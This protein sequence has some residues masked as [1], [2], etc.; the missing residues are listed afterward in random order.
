M[1]KYG[2]EEVPVPVHV[3]YCTEYF[4]GN[5]GKSNRVTRLDETANDDDRNTI[6]KYRQR[7]RSNLLTVGTLT[8]LLY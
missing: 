8:L 2:R 6:D 4:V 5:G 1:T 7:F 3:V